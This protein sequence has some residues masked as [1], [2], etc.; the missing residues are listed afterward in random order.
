MTRRDIFRCLPALPA[1]KLLAESRPETFRVYTESPRLFLR[2]Q[3]LKLLR[4][5]VERRSL[6]WEQFETLWTGNAAFPELGFAAALRYQI[7]KDDEAGKRAV[8]WALEQGEDAR[9]IAIV[10]DWCAPLI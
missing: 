8:F 2:P 9:Q 5:E 6:R 1:I 7:A 10:A 3:R 4:R